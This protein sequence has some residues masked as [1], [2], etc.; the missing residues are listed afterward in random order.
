M[1]AQCRLDLTCIRHSESLKYIYTGTGLKK[2]ENCC[3]E[4]KIYATIATDT[5]NK[6]NH[7]AVI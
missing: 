3:Y 1:S 4:V 7:L 2:S 6:R 5:Y